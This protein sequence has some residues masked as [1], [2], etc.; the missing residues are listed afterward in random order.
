LN[1][2]AY[3]LNNPLSKFDPDGHEEAL[4]KKWL[5]AI[6]VKVSAS[7]GTGGS[8]QLGKVGFKAE[9]TFAKAE[10]KI[11]LGGGN[12]D[13]KVESGVKFTATAGPAEASAKIGVE[14]SAQNGVGGGLSAGAKVSGT[15]LNAGVKIDQSGM[16]ATAGTVE[17]KSDFVIGGDFKFGVGIGASVNFSQF[18]RAWDSTVETAGQAYQTIKETVSWTGQSVPSLTP[19]LDIRTSGNQE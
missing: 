6:E 4:W 18:G 17:Q 14:A 10:A 5:N 13:V 8:V 3:V 12:G 15:G 1:R 19:A 2:Y 16:Q 7:A 11:G 9:M